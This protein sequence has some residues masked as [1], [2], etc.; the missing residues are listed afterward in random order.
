LTT[1]GALPP[2]LEAAP[3][4]TRLWVPEKVVTVELAV[5]LAVI[6]RLTAVPVFG[7]VVLPPIVNLTAS[8]I[9]TV[10]ALAALVLLQPCQ[11]ATT[12]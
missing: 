11:I 1:V 2:G 5:S 3:A 8:P 10:A 6:V 4:K 12:R 7:V 9:V